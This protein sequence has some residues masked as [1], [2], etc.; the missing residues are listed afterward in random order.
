MDAMNTANTK[1]TEQKWREEDEGQVK[2]KAHR[3]YKSSGWVYATAYSH[4]W[5]AFTVGTI[6]MGLLCALCINGIVSIVSCNSV[7]SILSL[8]SA[9]SIL[10]M[11]SVFSIN[12]QNG[13]FEIC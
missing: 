12:C 4:G 10:S 9:F 6:G 2:E 3:S 7:F 13:R 5:Q 8:N 11:N 1:T